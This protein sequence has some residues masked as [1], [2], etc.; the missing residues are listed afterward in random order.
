MQATEG[1]PAPC[2]R[3][4]HP[5]M[6][7]WRWTIVVVNVQSVDSVGGVRLTVILDEALREA[8]VAAQMTPEGLRLELALALYQL[9]KLS[10]G[11]ARELAGVSAW[12][13]QE[14]LGRC[15]T[16]SRSTMRTRP[17]CASAEGR[18][19]R[20][21]FL[22]ADQS[23]SPWPARACDASGRALAGRAPRR[24]GLSPGRRARSVTVP[25]WPPGRCRREEPVLAQQ[26]AA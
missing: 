13:F 16:T 8:L 7:D 5:F 19:R 26:R 23:R 14:M 3:E 4:T 9:G 18:E 24:R 6:H 17:S 20:E 1:A 25:P 11:K 10:F 22:A 21:Q 2:A 12:A 15:T